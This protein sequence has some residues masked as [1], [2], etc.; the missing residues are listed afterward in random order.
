MNS[1]QCI[2]FSFVDSYCQA[3]YWIETMSK[4][5]SWQLAIMIFV[6]FLVLGV[7]G[8]I[9]GQ[10][11]FSDGVVPKK[12]LP[13]PTMTDELVFLNVPHIRQKPGNCVP[14]SCAMVM[15]YFKRS[16][17]PGDLKRLAENHKPK[18][19]RNTEFTYWKDMQ[20]AL[21]SKN[22]Q[23]EI[24]RFDKTREGYDQGMSDIKS[25]L[26]SGQ[27]VL[28]DVHLGSGHTFVI[29]GFDQL[30]RLVF[31]RDPALP[32]NKAR[33]LTYSQMQQHWHNHRFGNSRSAF[34]SKK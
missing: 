8:D 13:K 23:W 31:I 3:N 14:T 29:I 17:S 20:I 1:L 2:E 34:F 26:L 15:R 30:K 27:P 16:A 6:G 24:R 25:H 10:L 22:E 4:R 9:R 5:L 19:E 33:V 28:I 7:C 11:Q 21:K 12:N 32:S 18:Q